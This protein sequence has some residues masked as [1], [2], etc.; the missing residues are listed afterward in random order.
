MSY[1]IYNINA[2]TSVVQ[3]PTSNLSTTSFTPVVL[4]NSV[5]APGQLVTIRDFEGAASLQ[6]PITVST[7]SGVNF[8]EGPQVSSYTITQPFGFMT[9]SPRTPSIWNVMNTFAFPD[10]NAAANINTLNANLMVVSS[11][12]ASGEVNMS[13]LNVSTLTV[14]QFIDIASTNIENAIVQS[15]VYVGELLSTGS[16]FAGDAS[17]LTLSVFSTATFNEL[18]NA[19]TINTSSLNAQS[20]AADSAFISSIQASSINVSA[21]ILIGP[22]LT[23]SSRL[24]VYGNADKKIKIVTSNTDAII[25]HTNAAGTNDTP[26]IGF[27]G[28]TGNLNVR[29]P[30]D[31]IMINFSSL[32]QGID[33]N[34]SLNMSNNI[35][36]LDQFKQSA[37]YY[38]AGDN[39]TY[40]KARSTK[41]IYIGANSN[42][43][44]LQITDSNPYSGT[45]TDSIISFNA[46]TFLTR[47]VNF[48]MPS[49]DRPMFWTGIVTQPLG[50]NTFSNYTAFL[51]TVVF[52]NIVNFS[53][54]TVQGLSFSN[55][56]LSNTTYT[57]TANFS[58]ATV[59]GLT[60]ATN[61]IS[62]LSVSTINGT[63]YPPVTETQL[64]GV[65][66]SLPSQTPGS[67]ISTLSTFRSPT[68]SFNESWTYTG[69]ITF[70]TT[71]NGSG[72]T[73]NLQNSTRTGAASFYR[74]LIINT[75][76]TSGSI[77][78]F[79]HTLT[80]TNSLSGSYGPKSSAS[81]FQI[82]NGSGTPIP[83]SVQLNGG[84]GNFYT[85]PGAEANITVWGRG[86]VIIEDSID[87]FLDSGDP[88]ASYAFSLASPVNA[89]NTTS[90]FSVITY[91]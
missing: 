21:E 81:T 1:A 49:P 66:F 9:V 25:Q 86:S 53:N 57:G 23:S 74:K 26:Y 51:S 11:V 34:T 68:Y 85:G 59:Q 6:Y 5:N 32:A 20:Y 41:S 87:W 70:L 61:S 55:I 22:N 31:N 19:S 75:T 72:N 63:P 30:G 17:T 38:D 54:A 4:L 62:S 35:I 82:T 73:Q 52:S 90:S 44:Q 40:L 89:A 56:S 16:F 67:G 39:N 50:S 8:L 13:S 24:V 77:D 78:L 7:V 47:A 84:T 28:T 46:S 36:H 48:N 27:G 43:Y 76:T 71:W 33:L 3:V 14:L 58:N 2:S 91:R 18:L 15:N 83:A 69:P 80:T 60:L 10:S 12:Y 37:L 79:L 64:W 65:S 42:P 29:D 45:N 88:G